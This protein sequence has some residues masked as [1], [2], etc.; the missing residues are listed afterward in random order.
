VCIS[1]V[2]AGETPDV[3]L[4]GEHFHPAFEV[5][6][7]NADPPP[8]IGNFRAMIADLPIDDVRRSTDT[9]LLG[10]LPGTVPVGTHDVIVEIPGGRRAELPKAFGIVDPLAVTAT[11]EHFRIPK[12]YFFGLDV[13]QHNRG[14]IPLT[15]ITLSLSQEGAG[16]VHLPAD[17]VLA[18][19]G[20]ESALTTTLPL[21]A[22]RQGFVSLLLEVSARVGDFVVVGTREPLVTGI[23][24]LPQAALVVSAELS[25]TEVGPGERFE[26]IVT[27][28][29]TGGVEALNVE[30]LAPAVSGSGSAALDNPS[31]LG[32]NIPAG[33]MRKIP[34]GGQALLWGTVVFAARVQGLEAISQR[35]L[36]PVSAESVSLEIR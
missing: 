35:L 6:I 13:T 5:D 24:V 22:E 29:N 7:G 16:Q 32:L 26:L 3:A 20:G 4:I 2:Y 12:G 10:T 15:Q 25:P 14:T 28:Y 17:S 21:W 8:L 36:G 19:L 23:L 1:E 31:P 30:V 9:L 34:W 18:A 33:S 11:P 27:V